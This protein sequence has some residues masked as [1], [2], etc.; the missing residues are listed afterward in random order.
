MTFRGGGG[1]LLHAQITT[2][3]TMTR[4]MKPAAAPTMGISGIL[5]ALKVLPACITKVNWLELESD[6]IT[7]YIQ[8]QPN[9]LIFCSEKD[10]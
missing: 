9:I 8:S 7:T 1:F 10:I 6:S 3:M 4:T 5:A 2:V